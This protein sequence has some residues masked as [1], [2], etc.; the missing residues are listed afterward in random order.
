MENILKHAEIYG[1]IREKQAIS[2]LIEAEELKN[3]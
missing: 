3:E 2:T 1:K